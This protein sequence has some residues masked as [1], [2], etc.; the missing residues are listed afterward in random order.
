MHGPTCIF[1]ANLTPFSL[2]WIVSSHEDAEVFTHAERDRE[3][4]VAHSIT[5]FMDV[6]APHFKSGYRPKDMDMSFM[7]D[8]RM[9][10]SVLGASHRLP[11]PAQLGWRRPS[12]SVKSWGADFT[13]ERVRWR[14]AAAAAAQG[15]ISGSSAAHCDRSAATS[16]AAGGWSRRSAVS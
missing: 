3:E 15:C 8:A 9:T 4:L 1:W 2:Q 12:F 14:H 5:H 13:R 6:H 7:S 11:A 10:S 16:S